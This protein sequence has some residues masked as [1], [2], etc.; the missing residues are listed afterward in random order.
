MMSTDND[1]NNIASTSAVPIESRARSKRYGYVLEYY[2]QHHVPGVGL[3]AGSFHLL[4]REPVAHPVM[5]ELIDL[6]VNRLI[7]RMI[8]SQQNLRPA[9]HP[10]NKVVLLREITT[11][12]VVEQFEGKDLE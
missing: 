11:Y 10:I 9:D 3:V 1:S 6:E 12:D 7:K 5:N 4:K 2:V 8:H